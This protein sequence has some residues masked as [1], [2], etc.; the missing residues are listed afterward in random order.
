[1]EFLKYLLIFL[2]VAQIWFSGLLKSLVGLIAWTAI[3]AVIALIHNL[4]AAQPWSYT[5]FWVVLWSW[6]ASTWTDLV[7]ANIG[8][9]I[10]T[11]MTLAS[12]SGS[13]ADKGSASGGEAADS[14]PK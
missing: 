13:S 11:L 8:V 2:L 10:A 5:G 14:T 9:G 7:H 6:S 1:M 12:L 4:F 3:W